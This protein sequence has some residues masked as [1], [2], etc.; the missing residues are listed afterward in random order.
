M[1][2]IVSEGNPEVKL[3]PGGV[4]RCLCLALAAA[5]IFQLFYLGAQP[6]AAG[7]VRVPWDKLAHLGVYAAITVLMWIGTAGRMPLAV[8]ATVIAVGV[9]DELHQ[10]S[11]PGRSAD[12]ADFAVD[13]CA[14]A[15]AGAVMLLLRTG[16]REG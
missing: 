14:A 11:L 2:I 8:I 7:L 12:M 9:F 5:I 10:A 6:M 16:R 4:L 1:P 13:V 3:E 15:G